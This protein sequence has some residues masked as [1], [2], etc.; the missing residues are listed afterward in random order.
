MAA[1]KIRKIRTENER[2]RLS[3]FSLASKDP[4]EIVETVG[5][6]PKSAQ[7]LYS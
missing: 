4:K 5:T 2:T 7:N 6:S 3:I 1:V